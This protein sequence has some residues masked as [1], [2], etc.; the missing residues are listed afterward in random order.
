[1]RGRRKTVEKFPGKHSGFLEFRQEFEDPS[2]SRGEGGRFTDF[3]RC[4][5]V[6]RRTE[7]SPEGRGGGGSGMHLPGGGGTHSRRG[8]RRSRRSGCPAAGSPC[9]PPSG[10][11]S[12]GRTAG[13]C[14]LLYS[15]PPPEIITRLQDVIMHLREIPRFR[16]V[17]RSKSASN[18]NTIYPHFIRTNIR[19]VHA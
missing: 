19:F 14:W 7:A 10:S 16:Y 17:L 12:R 11:S 5:L 9:S 3:N 1:M 13:T 4:R 15:W 2:R 6:G 18:H 8:T